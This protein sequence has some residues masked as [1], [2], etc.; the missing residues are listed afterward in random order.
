MTEETVTELF[1]SIARM[2]DLLSLSL[3]A[4]HDY[5]QEMLIYSCL[6]HLLENF[7][8]PGKLR[9]LQ[10][11]VGTSKKFTNIRLGSSRLSENPELV[12]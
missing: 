3:E 2:Q 5:E 6:H 7:A 11:W 1:A 12:L 10:S 4:M 8:F 9:T